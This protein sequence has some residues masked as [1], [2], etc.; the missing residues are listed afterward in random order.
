MIIEIAL[1][2]ALGLTLYAVARFIVAAYID[3]V[4]LAVMRLR[5]PAIGKPYRP[6]PFWLHRQLLRARQLA[7]MIGQEIPP[8]PWR[9]R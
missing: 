2:V 9:G 1:G 5:E 7:A 3:R 4:A 8:P 6:W